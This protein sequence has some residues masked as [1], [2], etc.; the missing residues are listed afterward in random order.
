MMEV[1]LDR[2]AREAIEQIDSRNYLLPYS[3]DGRQLT[4]I[5][6]SFSTEERNVTEWIIG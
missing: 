4:K 1:K 3:L 6:I 2:P 5:G